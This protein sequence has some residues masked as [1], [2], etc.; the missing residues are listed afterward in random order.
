MTLKTKKFGIIG[1][2]GYI[3][4]KHMAAIRNTGNEL[5]AALDPNDSVGVMDSY[6][7]DTEFFTEFERFDR[8]VHKLKRIG[9]SL[10]FISIC[11]PNYLHDSHVR[12]ALRS[13]SDAICEKPVVLNPHNIDGLKEIEAETGNKVNTI[14]QLRV[15]PSIIMLRNKLMAEVNPIKYEVKLTYIT[16]RGRWYLQSWKGF[17]EK[18][19]GI[20]TNIGIHF[21]DMLHYLFGEVESNTVH[22]KTK[23]R[24]SGVIEYERASVCWFLS[25]EISDMP[26]E[27]AK[28][29]NRTYRSITIDGHEIEFSEGF[30]DLHI[31][32]YEE[33]LAGRGFGLDDNRA[34][35]A[36]VSE[37]RKAV[38]SSNGKKHQ[39]MSV[40]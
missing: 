24:A 29:G 10:D 12:F 5:I 30:K 1:V 25:I 35:I 20:A 26:K 11:S 4:P 3:A 18:S 16:S 9:Q 39:F 37:I 38:I 6:F 19:G 13:G 7:P 2:A 34:A 17:D 21:F 15:H 33:L 40:L 22:L 8:H 27:L 36:I 14:L 31:K 28:N 32:S 23:T